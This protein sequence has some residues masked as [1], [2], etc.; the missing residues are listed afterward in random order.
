MGARRRYMR[1]QLSSFDKYFF[2]MDKN[3]YGSEKED[4]FFYNST[5]KCPWTIIKSGYK[6]SARPNPNGRPLAFVLY[7]WS[8]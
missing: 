1:S 5:A 3:Y 4:P 7:F 8:L 6:E 2:S